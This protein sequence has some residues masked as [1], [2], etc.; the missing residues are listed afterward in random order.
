MSNCPMTIDNQTRYNLS[1]KQINQFCRHG[2]SVKC[3]ALFD[4]W[5][6]TL[7]REA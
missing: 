7:T 1:T 4:E 6:K 2:C 5:V 3:K